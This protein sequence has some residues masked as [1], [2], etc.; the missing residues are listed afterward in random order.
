[1][2][3]LFKS[4][5]KN[6]KTRHFIHSGINGTWQADLYY[7]YNSKEKTEDTNY[8]LRNERNKNK[9]EDNHKTLYKTNKD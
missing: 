9:V 8:N 3:G 2:Y 1:M 4:S 6:F 5:R 7:F